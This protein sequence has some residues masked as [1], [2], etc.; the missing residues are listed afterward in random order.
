MRARWTLVILTMLL[1][2]STDAWQGPPR[3]LDVR[4]PS[5]AAIPGAIVVVLAGGALV[6]ETTTDETGR[7]TLAPPA[8]DARV[9]VSAPGFETVE[10]PLSLALEEPVTLPLARVESDVVVT[11]VVEQAGGAAEVLSEAELDQLPDD[12]ESLQRVLQDLAGPDA[13]IRVDGFGG[14]LPPRDQI[15]RITVRRDAY[16]AEFERPGRGRVDILTRPA[17]GRWRADGSVQF[18]PEGLAASNALARDAGAGTLRRFGGSLAGPLVRDRTA[19]FL[20][21]NVT[22]S[23]DTRGISALTPDG[24][25]IAAVEQP[26]SRLRVSGRVE[27]LVFGDAL[28]RASVSGDR[29]SRDNQGLSE[30]D[31]PERGYERRATGRSARV[32]LDGGVSRPYYVRVSWDRDVT[33]ALPDTAAPAIVVNSAFRAGGATV[34]GQDRRDRAEIESAVT[35]ATAPFTVRAGTQ[36]EWVREA[37]GQVRNARGTFT[38]VNLAAY[39]AGQP[40]TFTRRIGAEALTLDTLRGALFAQADRA[41]ES[42]WSL[43]TGLRYQAQTHFGDRAAWAPRFGVSRAANRGRTTLRFGYGWFYD[44]LP[45]RVREESVRL[46]RGSGEQEIIIR[47]PGYPDPFAAGTRDT[48][49]VD[50]PSLVAVPADADLTRWSRVSAG[51]SQSLP[52]GWRLGADVYRQWTGTAWRAVDSNAPVGGVRPDPLRG[53]SLIVD[54]TGR[55]ADTGLSTDIRYSADGRFASVRYRWGRRMNDGDDALTP[56]P[57]GRDIAGEWGLARNDPGHR[58]YWS[59]GGRLPWGVQA[60]VFG[61]AE[62]GNRYTVT[63]GLDAN[64]DALFIER[65]AG[66]TRNSERGTWEITMDL[67]LSWEM[68]LGAPPAAQR[69]RGGRGRGAGS[70]SMEGFVSVS[71]L[72]NRVNYSSYVGVLTSPLFGTPT[73]AGSARRIEVGWRIRY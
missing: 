49:D 34:E 40:A 68:P 52:G 32:S 24:R 69:R 26:S 67:R 55:E 27:S 18:R 9:I 48:P 60:A 5:G 6:E 16:S 2:V 38:F 3:A 30:L 58:V 20:S 36:L 4:D 35:V 62:Q 39:A 43:A 31:L 56:P 71:N 70:R 57:D 72:F 23:A 45:T 63:T 50:P 33:R 42:G 59:L 12:E 11:G 14:T 66:G 37:Q 54:A 7:A 10:R 44:W 73:S 13:E 64:G 15:M 28:M 51:I 8:G 25:L 22:D 21:A 46:S 19:V 47:N 41:W 29:S 17:A 61:R 1:S 53:R 65:P